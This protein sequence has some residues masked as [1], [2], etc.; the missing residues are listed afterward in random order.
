M[1]KDEFDWYK[2][3]FKP[4]LIIILIAAIFIAILIS[5]APSY[6]CFKGGDVVALSGTEPIDLKN[7]W[8]YINGSTITNIDR[9]IKVK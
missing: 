8:W 3:K 1:S 5:G 7:N 6:K 4:A 9:C 2:T